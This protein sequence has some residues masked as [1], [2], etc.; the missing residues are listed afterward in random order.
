VRCIKYVEIL[1]R[2]VEGER[3]ICRGVEQLNSS[4]DNGVV[5]AVGEERI[6]NN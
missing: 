1:I 5:G 3:D 6:R 2:E 4:Q